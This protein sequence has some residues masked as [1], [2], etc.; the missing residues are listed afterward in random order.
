MDY[1]EWTKDC[2]K[3]KACTRSC[4][5]L[6]KYQIDI[7]DVEELYDL[8]FHCFLCGKCDEVCPM[9]IRCREMILDMRRDRVQKEGIPKDKGYLPLLAEKSNYIFKNYRSANKKSVLFPGCNFAS[10]YP[11]TLKHLITLLEQ[12]QIGVAYDCCG[13]P[14]SEMGLV[15]KEKEILKN[16]QLRIDQNGIE[17]L[18]LLC[19][20]CYYYFEG[21]LDCKITFI[22]DKLKELGIGRTIEAHN[23]ISIFP[24]CPDRKNH[25]LLKR[26]SSFIDGKYR[27]IDEVQC[28]GLGGVAGVK[29]PLLAREMAES[30]A[31]YKKEKKHDISCLDEPIYTYCATCCGNIARKGKQ[32]IY[33][34]LTEILGTGEKP[35]IK[36]SVVNRALSKVR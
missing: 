31:Q 1:R 24:P 4:R 19:P 13:K 8:S 5:F 14:I 35:D 33:H 22:Y 27:V 20:N 15:D 16:I 32:E 7:G 21:R 9:G 26:L 10:F 17:E 3:C 25:A 30:L 36:K 29:E 6:T 18:I 34:L 28:C 2:I 23:E 11:K 12:Y